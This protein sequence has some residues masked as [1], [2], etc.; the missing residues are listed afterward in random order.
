M[1]AVI[2]GRGTGTTVASDRRERL[3]AAAVYLVG[4]VA[5]FI[6][7]E[8]LGLGFM[9]SPFFLGMVMLVASYFRPRLLASATLLAIWGTVVLLNGKFFWADGR[10]DAVY[11]AAFGV[12]ALVLVALQRWV[13]PRVSLETVG[14]VMLVTGVWYYLAYEYDALVKTW[15]WSLSMVVS[16]VALVLT[17]LVPRRGDSPDRASADGSPVRSGVGT[18]LP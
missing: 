17:T 18:R 7:R 8:V 6:A 14:I 11:L 15:V 9:A 12:G 4:A 10:S 5:Y 3:G 13:D 2:Y 1:R 16:A